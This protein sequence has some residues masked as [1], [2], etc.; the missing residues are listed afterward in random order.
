MNN[1]HRS[2]I[3]AILKYDYMYL[4]KISLKMIEYCLISQKLQLE[5]GLDRVIGDRSLVF[6]LLTLLAFNFDGLRLKF[7]L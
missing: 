1:S 6:T 2:L 3:T 4:P 5:T 7:H